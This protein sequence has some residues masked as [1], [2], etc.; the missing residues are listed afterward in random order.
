MHCQKE[1]TEGQKIEPK[2]Q[3]PSELKALDQ[4]VKESPVQ[5]DSFLKKDFDLEPVTQVP[6]LPNDPL[7]G[8]P[9]PVKPDIVQNSKPTQGIEF[10]KSQGLESER[11]DLSRENFAQRHVEEADE[12]EKVKVKCMSVKPNERA[13]DPKEQLEPNLNEVETAAPIESSEESKFETEPPEK[14]HEFVAPNPVPRKAPPSW[15]VIPESPILPS[16]MSKSNPKPEPEI[17]TAKSHACLSLDPFLKP[18]RSTKLSKLK[19]ALKRESLDENNNC[20]A[21]LIRRTPKLPG[22]TAPIL[23]KLKRIHCSQW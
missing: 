8:D 5:E 21:V 3:S 7:I 11:V 2:V 10:S 16:T 19:E 18:L 13:D 20:N 6:P 17:S 1:Q 23:S 14:V 22:S 9:L 12:D 15:K 4:S